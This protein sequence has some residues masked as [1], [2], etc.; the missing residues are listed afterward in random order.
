M[1]KKLKIISTTS[2]DY[3]RMAQCV[4]EYLKDQ[5]YAH[6]ALDVIRVAQYFRE[7]HTLDP[8]PGQLETALLELQKTGALKLERQ[9]LTP[10]AANALPSPH[11]YGSKSAHVYPKP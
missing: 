5:G 3:V 7:Q 6:R 4:K 10:L 9:A 1:A 2:M 8:N 11:D